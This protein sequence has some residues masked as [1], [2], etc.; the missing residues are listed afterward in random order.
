MRTAALLLLLAGGRAWALGEKIVAVDVEGNTKTS[1][2]TIRDIA[3]VSVG[4]QLTDGLVDRVK[5]DLQ[6]C[7]LFKEVNVTV[8][9]QTLATVRLKINAQDKHSWVIAPTFYT[10]PG[11]IGG[12]IGFAENNLFGRNKKLLLY[13]QIATADSFF[14]G[15]YL[16]PAIAGSRFYWRIDTVL[17]HAQVTE[18]DSPDAFLSQPQSFRITT[19]NYLNLGVVFGMNLWKGWSI[20]GRLRGARVFYRDSHWDKDNPDTAGLPMT[21]PPPEVDGWDVSTEWKLTLDRRASWNGVTTGYVLQLDAEHSL[22]AL[23]S[24]YGYWLGGVRGGYYRRIFTTHNLT[25]KASA[26]QGWH[27]PFQQELTAGGTGLRGYKNQQFRGDLRITST[28]EYSAQL[29]WIK[30]LAFR[31]LAFWDTAYTAFLMNEGNT[32]RDYLPGETA[33]K[34]SHWRNGVGAGLRVYVKSVVL[35]LLGVDI[36]Y[37][38]EARDYH[39]YLAVGLTEL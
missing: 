8:V 32:M 13:A 26:M 33:N 29:F 17:R 6:T 28:M 36:G 9:P 15:G 24:D 35:P 14:L 4:D 30:A 7:G 2:D 3:D 18:Y 16:D 20:D 38:I 10:Q 23:G 21:T 34:I 11:N 31:A 27:L 39:L 12:G 5:V 22:G 1:D 25:V 19:Q 37:G